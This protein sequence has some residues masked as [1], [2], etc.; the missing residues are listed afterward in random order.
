MSALRRAAERVKDLAAPETAT[1][2]SDDDE[3]SGETTPTLGDLYL[4]GFT[5]QVKITIAVAGARAVGKTSLIHKCAGLTTGGTQYNSTEVLENLG[6][7]I[8]SESGGTI[9]VLFVGVPDG[10]FMREE[11][12]QVYARADAFVM[13]FNL[14][15]LGTLHA[16]RTTV[17]SEIM[18]AKG[19]DAA[20]DPLDA[21]CVLLGNKL[22]ESRLLEDNVAMRDVSQAS[23]LMIADL[24]G[25]PYR[26]VSALTGE[27][28]P[29]WFNEFLTTA[30]DCA[31]R[32]AAKK[33]KKR[34]NVQ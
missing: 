23:A 18:T 32:D 11:R 26:E 13:V 12:R 9:K 4:A 19:L 5:G 10:R 29:E 31:T 17:F 21:P 33:S 24:I 22:D 14:N 16:V 28:V 27:G 3:E 20:E 15:D 1:M 7:Y 30:V 2:H 8:Q 34:C 6:L 25:C